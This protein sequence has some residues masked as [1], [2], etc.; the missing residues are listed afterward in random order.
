M[1]S[2]DLNPNLDAAT[3]WTVDSPRSIATH[4]SVVV[5]PLHIRDI[6]VI[7][8][9]HTVKF[10]MGDWAIYTVVYSDVRTAWRVR[11][12]IARAWHANARRKPATNA[13]TGG[14]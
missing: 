11:A 13:L 8:P 12:E 5:D 2:L 10:Q 9:S 6:E 7:R 14:A 4:A 1:S 3:V